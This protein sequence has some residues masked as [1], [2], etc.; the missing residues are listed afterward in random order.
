MKNQVTDK[1]PKGSNFP[2]NPSTFKDAF[3]AE[4]VDLHT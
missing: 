1:K 4:R 2:T 3:D